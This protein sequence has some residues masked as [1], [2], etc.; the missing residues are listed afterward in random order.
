MKKNKITSLPVWKKL[1]SH[2]RL[3]ETDDKHLKLLLQDPQRLEKFSLQD[4]GIFYD[5]SRQRVD[6]EAMELLFELAEA[7]NLT[8]RFEAMM[9][10]DKVNTTENRAALHTA[11][12]DFSGNP[13]VVDGTDVAL[14][15]KKVRE[16]IE[17]FSRQ[18]HQGE[19]RGST[20]KPF[21]H[22]V[23]IGIGGSYLGAQFVSE[24]LKAYAD[25][26][27]S[28]HYLANVDIHN[29]G[30]I[31]SS[32]EP[33]TTL[34]IVISKSYTTA[35]T[36]ANVAQAKAYRRTTVETAKAQA[37]YFNQLLVEYQKRPKLVVD[38]IYQD[39]IREVLETADEKT[40]LQPTEGAKGKEI[41]III[42]R[43]PKIKGK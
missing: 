8:V 39:T 10:G 29:F 36:M 43:D 26:G 7:R 13:V 16:D 31:V 38:R 28:L 6:E 42:S 1:E 24:A 14:M 12:R 15:I 37:D 18:V 20:G 32:I 21:E 30:E 9:R 25:R 2:A 4:A 3:M 34:W 5:F 41:R 11:A 27:I 40:I 33:E 23:V 17:L 35:E 19:I 22:I